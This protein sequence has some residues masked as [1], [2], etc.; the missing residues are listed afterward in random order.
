MFH[1]NRNTLRAGAVIGAIGAAFMPHG[2]EALS[3]Y[4]GGRSVAPSSGDYLTGTY[5][6]R[7]ND[8]EEAYRRYSDLGA[9]Q[10]TGDAA[11]R[12]LIA[13]VLTGN[14]D[15][16]AQL[17]REGAVNSNRIL[18]GL[19]EICEAIKRGE[20]ARLQEVMNRP[21]E[22]VSGAPEGSI[23]DYTM[24]PL[25]RAWYLAAL[26]NYEMA[27]ERLKEEE[28]RKFFT[29][30][31][32]A[33]QSALMADVAGRPDAARDAYEKLSENADMPYY[34]VRMLGNYYEREGKGGLAVDVYEGY[35][36][37]AERPYRFED[38]FARIAEGD[39]PD[40]AV[41]NFAGGVGVVLLE[42]ARILADHDMLAEAMLYARL[43]EYIA[44]E[45]QETYAIMARYYAAS[46]A[47]D[48]PA[49]IRA[50]LERMPD[51]APDV[52]IM[53]A[54]MLGETERYGEAGEALENVLS[55]YPA[56]SYARLVYADL[57]RRQKR[58][59]EAAEQYE[60][61]IAAETAEDKDI[62]WNVHFALAI[63]YERMN[64]WENAEIHL[65]R[66][67]AKDPDQPDVLNYLAYGRL[68][69][70]LSPEKAKKMIERALARVSDSPHIV[71][72][73]G[74]AYFKMKEYD[75]AVQYLENAATAL[76]QDPVINDHL[77]DAYW[78]AGRKTEAVFQWKRAL[79]YNEDGQQDADLIQA[80]I[81]RGYHAGKAI[82]AETAPRGGMN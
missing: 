69:R 22:S 37:R 64:D 72:S 13:S 76:P 18:P 41:E 29:G 63:C 8:M 7:N 2:A 47:E 73:L 66:A 45:L 44:P 26:G 33:L 21:A 59:Q 68:E 14:V 48:I 36:E 15:T 78:H 6:Y 80:K 54:G 67:L 57:L 16:A 40:A 53:R 62:S 51:Q 11:Y 77:G 19:A 75:K 46:G 12:Y 58:F 42:T 4:A 61:V 38:A 24:V 32:L 71:D 10:I 20:W 9:G 55:S 50:A 23:G 5:F 43:S 3:P 1:L 79:K 25:I 82:A 74:W 49:D 30:A 35:R 60:A 52:A 27:V 81:E 34:Y 28:S 65:Q 31:F 56:Y 39:I 17:L 70:G